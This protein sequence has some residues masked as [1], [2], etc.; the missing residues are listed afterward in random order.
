MDPIRL[1]PFAV[2]R[3][4]GAVTFLLVLASIGCQLSIYLLGHANLY[5]LVP[6]FNMDS[7]QNIPTLFSVL[8]LF[9]A[10]L[11]LTVIS[12]LKK[13][14]R[15]PEVLEFGVLAFGFLLMTLD[16]G[17]SL[18]ERLVNPIRWLLGGGSLGIFYF[19]WVI[20]GM[21]VLCVLGLFFHK[22][23]LTLPSRTR[24]HFLLAATL[25]L[26]GAIGIELVEGRH[27][28]L[29]GRENLTYG[30]MTALEEGLEMAGVIVFI[31][32]LMKYIVENYKEVRL[33]FDDFRIDTQPKSCLPPKCIRG[34]A[35]QQRVA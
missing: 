22:F 13:K 17:A 7:E 21:G 15:D 6:L 3:S 26:G 16:E 33:V 1:N 30:M 10:S 27:V 18:H 19:A 4:L 11:L 25:Y 32:A 28:E 9:S 20:P 12:L 34:D 14:H 31:Y 35:P 8:L 24:F 23:L 29:Y 2:A 5:G